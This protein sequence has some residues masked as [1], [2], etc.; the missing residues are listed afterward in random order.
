MAAAGERGG[1]TV[2]EMRWQCGSNSA[3]SAVKCC[4]NGVS[5]LQRQRSGCNGSQMH[6]QVQVAAVWRQQ[7]SIGSG[8]R[9]E[10]QDNGCR[11]P[12]RGDPDLNS[13]YTGITTVR[14]EVN[15]PEGL[16]LPKGS[17]FAQGNHQCRIKH[18]RW[19]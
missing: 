2:A 8:E 9:G 1:N 10:F 13:L 5:K 4:G 6:Q 3:V 12:G 15:H 16:P 14:S 19:D 11:K 17:I 7:Q 18:T